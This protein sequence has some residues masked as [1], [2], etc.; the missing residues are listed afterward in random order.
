[1]AILPQERLGMSEDIFWL[2]QLEGVLL[3]S[4]G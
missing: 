1:M 4:N 2:S 3:A